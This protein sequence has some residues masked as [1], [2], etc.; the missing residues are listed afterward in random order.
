VKLR[1]LFLQTVV[2]LIN[3]RGRKDPPNATVALKMD[4]EAF[5]TVMIDAL[6]AANAVSPVN[7]V[8]SQAVVP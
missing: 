4:V 7:A 2:D 6:T 8:A 5:W 1:A 3:I